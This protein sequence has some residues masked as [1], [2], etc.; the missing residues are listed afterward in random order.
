MQGA[1]EG[2]KAHLFTGGPD[3]PVEIRK[4]AIGKSPDEEILSFK[5]KHKGDKVALIGNGES[6]KKQ[7]LGNIDCWT[8]GLNH[9]WELGE[10]DYL[11][12]GDPGQLRD[13]EANV[14]RLDQCKGLFTTHASGRK[15][16]TRIVGL[17]SDIKYFSF[18]ALRGFYLNNTI[19]SFGLQL[20]V[21]MGFTTIYLVG[22]DAQGG[23]FYGGREIPEQK[24]GNQRETYGLIAGIM[25]CQ[26]PDVEIINLNINSAVRVFPKQRFEKVFG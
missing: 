19:C 18:D 13:Y 11:A 10:W 26:R 7:R 6:V 3:P 12:M 17:T 14:G 5:D 21:W 2:Q 8:I 23:H 24:F 15:A 1:F 20:A 9:A 16:G 22:V 4:Q 25:R